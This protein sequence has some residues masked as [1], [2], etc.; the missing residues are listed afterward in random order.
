MSIPTR[1]LKHFA[2]LLFVVSI[3]QPFPCFLCSF[4]FRSGL[5]GLFECGEVLSWFLACFLWWATFLRKPRP[6]LRVFR[7]PSVRLGLLISFFSILVFSLFSKVPLS[8][9]YKEVILLLRSPSCSL[10]R[11]ILVFC[12][13]GTFFFGRFDLR[14]ACGLEGNRP[15][16]PHSVLLRGQHE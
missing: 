5:V 1:F 12:G 9:R 13:L 14:E 7:N 8:G 16:F 4:L 10:C 6:F 3:G 11:V 2:V 15:G